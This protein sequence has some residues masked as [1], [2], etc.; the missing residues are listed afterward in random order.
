MWGLSHFGRKSKAHTC[1]WI[2]TFSSWGP[3]FF[4]W[5]A[6]LTALGSKIDC[7]PWCSTQLLSFFRY[8]HE[9][10]VLGDNLFILGGGTSNAVL[11][12]KKLH[13][14]NTKLKCWVCHT[15]KPDVDTGKHR[16]FS[17]FCKVSWSDHVL[18]FPAPRRCHGCVQLEHEAFISGGYDGVCIMK[19]IWK[20]DLQ[21]L[22]WTRIAL[23]PEPVYFHSAAASPVCI[24]NGLKTYV[25]AHSFC[26]KRRY[27]RPRYH[28]CDRH[29]IIWCH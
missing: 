11:S 23:M 16:A 27:S 1:A 10:G 4:S 25:L 2:L 14:Y 18:G 3:R 12:L 13:C 8:R 7:Y 5:V 28:R 29:H 22:Q 21:Q 24:V 6:N 15:T 26:F 17:T 19:D 9:I 20:I